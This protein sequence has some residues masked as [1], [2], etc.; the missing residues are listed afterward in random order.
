MKAQWGSKG[1]ELLFFNLGTGWRWVVNATLHPLYPRE[2]PRTHCTG[3]WQ[4]WTAVEKLAPTGGRNHDLAWLRVILPMP[5][6]RLGI[7]VYTHTHTYIHTYIHT[8]LHTYI[9]THIYI[10]T[11]WRVKFSLP[12]AEFNVNNTY[13]CHIA[14]GIL[15]EA[16]ED[17][18][19]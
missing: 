16:E 6:F 2:R 4:A 5:Y 1:I 11:Y 14:N 7:Y 15:K 13:E 8:Y 3:G 18:N 10:H 17:L 9:P 19:C 12:T